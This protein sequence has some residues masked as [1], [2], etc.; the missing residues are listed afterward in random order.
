MIDNMH[1]TSNKLS[2]NEDQLARLLKERETQMKTALKNS[3]DR[4]ER[5]ATEERTKKE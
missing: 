1:D 3:E 4:L 5:N 2:L